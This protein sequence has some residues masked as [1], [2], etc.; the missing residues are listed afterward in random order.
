MKES[1]NEGV[2]N[3]V[4][5]ESWI[6]V[7][8]GDGQ[9]LT[10][11]RVGRVSSRE[12]NFPQASSLRLAECRRRPD[13]RKATFASPPSRGDEELCAVID[14]EHARTHRTREPGDPTT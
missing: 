7:G 9:A 4:G 8:N 14:P 12:R 3:H 5:P 13:G 2:A 10:G 1:N 6:V 11:E